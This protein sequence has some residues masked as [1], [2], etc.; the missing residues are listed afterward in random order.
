VRAMGILCGS[1]ALSLIL[2]QAD[3]MDV[4]P[5][6]PAPRP[7]AGEA[8]PA[9]DACAAGGELQKGPATLPPHWS[10]NQC[11]REIPDGATY[12]V[13]ARGDT[14]W[15]IS[16]RFLNNPYFWPQIW[17]AN[18][19]I[20]DA[21]WI[22]PC[23][24]LIIPDIAVVTDRAGEGEGAGAETEEERLRRE[25]EGRQSVTDPLI[26][27]IEETALQCAG[28]VVDDR[29][30]ESLHLAGS[31]EGATKNTF[32]DRDILYLNKGSNSGVK[33]GDVYS[34]HHVAY[35]VKH[36]D[37]GRS[38]GTKIETTGWARVILVQE[39]TATVTVE[40]ACMDIHLGDYLKPFE[41]LPIPLIARHAPP[42]RMT[43]PTG[44]L[45]GTV[46]DIAEDGMIAGERQLVTLNIGSS[47]GVAPGNLFS[48]YKIMYP[49]VPTPRN[50][51]GELVV[52][53][54]RE[55]TA[56]ARVLYSRDAIMNGDK[57]ELR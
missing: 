33:A 56:T 47:N 57:A 29:E 5:A 40:Q 49:S 50:V 4:M 36:P 42:D 28:Y 1:A 10:R 16:K 14:L 39:N 21:H 7:A 51:I 8:A 34:L 37:T 44:R 32:G 6:Q 26:P 41:K 18:R 2:V 35:T 31:E 22:Y 25:A 19:C 27:A 46:V 30:D 9:A 20:T 45:T 55:R 11:P 52:V 23:D 24:A 15:D 3:A 13:I 17:N 48:V 38:I 54:V 43:P 12:Y 53:A